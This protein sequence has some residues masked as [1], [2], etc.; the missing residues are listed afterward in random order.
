M[1]NVLILLLFPLFVFTQNDTIKS[2]NKNWTETEN[3]N[4]IK[5]LGKNV[6]LDA[7]LVF[8]TEAGKFYLSMGSGPQMNLNLQWISDINIS[9]N[10]LDS[11]NNSTYWNENLKTTSSRVSIDGQFGY[12]IADG[13]V[14]GLGVSYN[15]STRN[16]ETVDDFD[17]DGYD[18]KY[19]YK[20]TFSSLSLTPFLKYYI[21]VGHNALFVKTSYQFSP[22][23]N[24][25]W[26]DEFDYTSYTNITNDSES[27]LK[28]SRLD[29]GTGMA[30]FLTESIAIEPSINYAILMSTVEQEVYVGYNPNTNNNIYELQEKRQI[31]NSIYFGIGASMYF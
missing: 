18:D 12:F 3:T 20:Y 29:F 28:S 5:K 19:M 21:D 24:Q 23:Y 22:F 13:L 25:E 15:S 4:S 16:I 6:L 8:K 30:F 9:G 7:K 26:E 31:D 11:T 10:Y 14:T 27:T 1:K 17:G 2:K